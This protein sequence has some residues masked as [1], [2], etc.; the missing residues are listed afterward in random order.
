M[1]SE[2]NN[3]KIC[4]VCS[5]VLILDENLSKSSHK[6][7]KN[8]CKTCSKLE[9]KK[10]NRRVNELSLTEEKYKWKRVFR[11]IRNRISFMRKHNSKLIC[12]DYKLIKKHLREIYPVLPTICPIE[13]IDLIY[14]AIPYD[15]ERRDNSISIDRINPNLGYVVDNIQILSFLANTIKNNAT[16]EQVY[17]L[18]DYYNKTQKQETKKVLKKHGSVFFYKNNMAKPHKKDKKSKK[19]G[20]VPPSLVDDSQLQFDFG[21]V[22]NNKE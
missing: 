17:N 5:V 8:I 10:Y 4:R 18:F 15:D 16:V 3:Q 1:E 11:L 13:K 20:G 6:H 2:S 7:G 9:G 14:S 22:L 21:M 19:G 12:D